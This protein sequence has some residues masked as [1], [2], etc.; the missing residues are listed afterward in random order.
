MPGPSSRCWLSGGQWAAGLRCWRRPWWLNRPTLGTPG[1]G[2]HV[3]SERVWGDG[4]RCLSRTEGAGPQLQE[5]G[6]SEAASGLAP[7]PW[8]GVWGT[9]PSL[10]QGPRHASSERPGAAATRRASPCRALA[11]REGPSSLPPPHLPR[12]GKPG[13][14][15]GFI[16]LLPLLETSEMYRADKAIPPPPWKWTPRPRPG[17]KPRQKGEASPSPTPHLPAVDVLELS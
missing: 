7:R 16:Q 3:V 10:P 17:E 13:G 12:G 11:L 1:P 5:P 4:G 9:A 14:Q 2:G 6:L 8:A 15:K